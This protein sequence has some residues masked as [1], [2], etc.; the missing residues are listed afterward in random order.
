MAASRKHKPGL[1]LADMQLADGSSSLE[2]VNEIL[3]SV[4][5]PVIFIK[6]Y[7]E[8]LLT[9]RRPEP[10]FLINK[11]FQSETV[12]AIISQAL[13]FENKATKSAA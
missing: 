13:F 1:I 9:G 6:A 12:K 3:G 4:E 5:V 11:P 10:T 2:A 8:G 7:P